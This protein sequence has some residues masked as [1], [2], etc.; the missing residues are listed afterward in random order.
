MSLK[1]IVQYSGGA[2][3]FATALFLVQNGVPREDILCLFA[4]TKHE[5]DDLHIFLEQTT[6]YLGVELIK[7]ADGRDIWQVFRDVRFL[8][9]SRVDPCSRILKREQCKKFI[10]ANFTPDNCILYVGIDWTEV[11]RMENVNRVRAP[12]QVDAPLTR[13]P[14]YDKNT[15]IAWMRTVGI[16][17]PSLY[18]DG[19][20]H[21]NC[22]GFCIKAGIAHF[23]HMLKVRPASYMQWERKEQEF[24]D[25]L[26]ADVAVLRD[27]RIKL[28]G[29]VLPL[30]LRVLRERESRKSLPPTMGS[31]TG[32]GVAA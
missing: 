5:D 2:G 6:R 25:F 12:Y 10:E 28:N 8:G 13:V 29:K 24:R 4:D 19:A 31:T 30:T 22:Q 17:P 3:S 20:P 9:N 7:I 21:S 32:E 16:L 15:F 23:L 18:E 1:H 14:S 26:Q 27:R 11:H